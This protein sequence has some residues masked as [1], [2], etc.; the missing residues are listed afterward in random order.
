MYC[1]ISTVVLLAFGTALYLLT[2]YYFCTILTIIACSLHANLL[3][4]H[5]LCKLVKL[6]LINQCFSFVFLY[7][8]CMINY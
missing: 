3:T 8:S 6:S 5:P 1:M 7:L 2:L 4:L